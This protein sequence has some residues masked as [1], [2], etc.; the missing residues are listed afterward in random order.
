M[1]TSNIKTFISFINTTITK[2]G[3]AL[4]AKGKLF[5]VVR[6]EIGPTCTPKSPKKIIVGFLSKKL[7]NRCKKIKDLTR[8]TINEKGGCGKS[9][10]P[11][12]QRHQCISKKGKAKLNN[13][14][15]L[16]LGRTILLM[17]M[18]TRNE[19][20]DANA[21]KKGIQLVILSS[22]ICLQG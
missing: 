6:T 1:T 10:I 17:C 11:K 15:M 20:R 22:P 14:S 19:I 16:M 12:L 21:C 5:V 13:M 4:R 7:F 2:E 9:L 3:A 8:Q 18:R